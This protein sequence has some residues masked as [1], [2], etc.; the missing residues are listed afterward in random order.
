MRK[1][2]PI[3]EAAVAAKTD[4]SAL[5]A[6]ARDSRVRVRRRVAANPATL[7]TDRQRLWHKGIAT[8]D[9]ELVLTLAPV[10]DAATVVDTYAEGSRAIG[11]GWHRVCQYTVNRALAAD[12]F[13][14][15]ALLL[16][17]GHPL[18]AGPVLAATQLDEPVGGFE[19]AAALAMVSDDAR[20][21]VLNAA[22]AVTSKVNQPLAAA[23]AVEGSWSRVSDLRPGAPSFAFGD[24]SMACSAQALRTL[25]YE[26]SLT[27]DGARLLTEVA[28]PGECVDETVVELTQRCAA[29]PTSRT[30]AQ[31]LAR[32]VDHNTV[33]PVHFDNIFTAM[34]NATVGRTYGPVSEV[35]TK[36]CAKLPIGLSTAAL[37]AAIRRDADVLAAMLRGEHPRTF[38]PGELT[39][40]V[41][42]E[43][44]DYTVQ[45]DT[46]DRLQLLGE[47]LSSY[48][49]GREEHASGRAWSREALDLVADRLLHLMGS[50]TVVANMVATEVVRDLG[51]DAEAWNTFLALATDGLGSEPLSSLLSAVRTLV[52]EA[53]PLV[54]DN[55]QCRWDF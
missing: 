19:F 4:P 13:D 54:A 29:N 49:W 26:P 17:S 36:L 9:Y 34:A 37:F 32:L 50:S 42:G 2:A 10:I 47:A 46:S 3:A 18:L 55:G 39:A 11:N 31:A 5:S 52:P 8:A 14:D 22:L 12:G 43:V 45:L 51:N 15:V 53:A 27:G 24:P 23:F 48:M 6:A 28:L 41:N 33:D 21:M 35:A 7:P 25:L 40:W 44:P 1:R 20:P 30:W 16:R 38:A